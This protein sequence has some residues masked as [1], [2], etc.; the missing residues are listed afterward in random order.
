MGGMG[1]EREIQ[2]GVDICKHTADSLC[3]AEIN[4]IW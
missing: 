3:T 1:G 2:E 4:T